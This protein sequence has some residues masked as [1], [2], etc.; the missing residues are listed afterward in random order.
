MTSPDLADP[1]TRLSGFI[2]KFT[3]AMQQRIRGCREALRERLPTAV[4]LVYDNYNFLVIGFGPTAKPSEAWFSL[5][6]DRNGTSLVFLQRGPELPDPHG[7][8]RGGGRKVRNVRLTDP[9][10]VSSPEVEALIQAEL[11]LASIPL[12]R[13]SGPALVIRSVSPRQ[14]PRQ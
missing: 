11:E 14:R 13:A 5:T 6:A 12:T 2:A 8:L 10:T 7:L 3:P 4:E 9:G 1:E